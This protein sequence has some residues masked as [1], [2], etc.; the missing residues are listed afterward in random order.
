M[1]AARE[2]ILILKL[3]GRPIIQLLPNRGPKRHHAS[4]SPSDGMNELLASWFPGGSGLTA[5]DF[6]VFA[7]ILAAMTA[8]GAR[9]GTGTLDDYVRGGRRLPW[10]AA[11]LAL[12]AAEVSALTIIGVPAT[13]FRG[14]WVFLQFF[15][16][17]AA[18]RVLVAGFIPAFF[19]GG[20][21]L[22]GYLGER[23]GPRTRTAAAGAFVAS[24]LLLSGVRLL[25]AGVAAGALLGWGAPPTLILFTVVALIALSRGGAPAAVW[26][27]AFQAA[28][29]LGAGALSALYLL[30]RVDGGLPAAL[31]VA[32]AASK[33]RFFSDPAAFAAAFV[34]GFFGS[35]AAFGTDHEL[36][37]KLLVVEDARAG[38]QAMLASILGSLLVLLVYLLIGTLLFVFYKQNPGLALPERLDRIFPHFAS[39]AMPRVL[40]GLVLS[41]IVMASI[42]A[43]LASLSSAYVADIRR[44]FAPGATPEQELAAARRAAVFFALA[45]AALAAWF[46]SSENA[47]SLAFKAG[48]ATSGPMLGVFALALT[49]KRRGDAAVVSALGAMIALNLALLGLAETGRLAMSWS[50]LVP[51]GAAATYALAWAFTDRE[52]TPAG[53]PAA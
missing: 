48:G 46:A 15:L 27:G 10:P 19:S 12:V 11:A 41:A 51:S 47:L 24:R 1:K 50:W 35:A 13:A 4:R 7:V 29:F 42:D 40:R 43:P 5:S 45:L 25:A 39:T 28:V 6:A 8:V 33:M 32:S 3:Y 9:A 49:S 37:Q 52:P 22:Y 36:A 44:A 34:T 30:H 23:F 20:D 31:N 16:G 26:T 14:D 18:A 2:S 53:G 38:R 17:A 21:T